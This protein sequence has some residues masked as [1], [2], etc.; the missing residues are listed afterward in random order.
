MASVRAALHGDVARDPKSNLAC[1]AERIAEYASACSVNQKGARIPHVVQPTARTHVPATIHLAHARKVTSDRPFMPRRPSWSERQ[2]SELHVSA[3]APAWESFIA[4]WMP[5][6]MAADTRTTFIASDRY[7]QPFPG[8]FA[9]RLAPATSRD[10]ASR[11]RWGR[12]P[13]SQWR[14]FQFEAS[15]A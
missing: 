6:T 10:G 9:F 15:K 3:D 5:T 14:T 13:L 12:A 11:P 7:G 8:R 1:A 4:R 2:S